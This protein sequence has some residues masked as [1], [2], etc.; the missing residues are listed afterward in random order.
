MV[1]RG[2]G[3]HAGGFEER[4][5]IPDIPTGG[6]VAR[7]RTA[8]R[9][10]RVGTHR[11]LG[12][13]NAGERTRNFRDAPTV[14]AAHAGR[15]AKKIEKGVRKM[16]KCYQLDPDGYLVAEADAPGGYLPAG[17][18]LADKEPAI[19]EGF[20]PCWDGK[21]WE[22]VENHKGETIYVD[23]NLFTVKTYGPLPEGWSLTPPPPTL[24]ETRAAK[25]A[26]IDAQT[27][28]AITSGFDCAVGEQTLRFSY[29]AHDQ[30]NFADTGNA[31]T[32]A[33]IGVP[34]IP[35]SVTWN[36]WKIT[37][38]EEGKEI[39][40]ALVRLT[41]TP[42]EFLSLYMGGALTH[43]ATQM[44]IG[45]QRKAAAEVAATVAELDAI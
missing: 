26:Q 20:I 42:Q 38:N 16:A 2:N 41:L 5:V 37:R 21:K 31:A 28:A 4:V 19:K 22:Q 12:G 24:E 14:Y 13:D 9:I 29:D 45:G 7:P 35:A 1:A 36:G 34:G 17:A 23:G 27:S 25:I 30:Q 18:I 10:K 40:R 3:G 39:S 6:Y 43:K 33:T 11:P 32:L 15:G 44:E 8:L